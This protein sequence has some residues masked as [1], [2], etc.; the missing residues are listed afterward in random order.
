MQ[1]IQTSDSPVR[2]DIILSVLPI[3]VAVAQ[4]RACQLHII[5]HKLK[6]H[7]IG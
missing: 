3:A 1:T 5:D 4:Q 7:V 2:A 6:Y